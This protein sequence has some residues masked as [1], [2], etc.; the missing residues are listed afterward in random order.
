MVGDDGPHVFTRWLAS[1]CYLEHLPNVVE[2]EPKE[3]RLLDELN[4]FDRTPEETPNKGPRGP[5][6][7]RSMGGS[8]TGAVLMEKWP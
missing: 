2:L 8:L 1:G 7:P 6:E 3:L 5:Q 4:V